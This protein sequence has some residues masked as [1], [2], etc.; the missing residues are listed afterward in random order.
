MPERECPQ[1]RSIVGKRPDGYRG[2]KEQIS[3][4]E[5]RK[6]FSFTPHLI[7]AS[8][9]QLKQ[10]TVGELVQ[11]GAGTF[12]LQR[13]AEIFDIRQHALERFEHISKCL[14]VGGR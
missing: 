1:F 2:H 5:M 10:S 4:D 3:D 11:P 14:S 6:N 7:T 8:T 12:V 9:P 13:P